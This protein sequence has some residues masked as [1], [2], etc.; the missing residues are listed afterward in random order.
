MV[1]NDSVSG[2]PVALVVNMNVVA[3]SAPWL[4]MATSMSRSAFAALLKLLLKGRYMGLIPHTSPNLSAL[5]GGGVIIAQS[6][7]RSDSS[8]VRDGS[9]VV[10][11][12]IRHLMPLRRAFP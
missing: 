1:A 10:T 11:P 12:F 5:L 6:P 7:V 9:A 3:L 8:S 2:A 4:G